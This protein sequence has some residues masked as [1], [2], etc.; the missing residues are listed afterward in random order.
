MINLLLGPPGGGKSYEAVV[1]HVL[2]A[3]QAGRR[4]ITNLPLDMA[5]L[6]AIDPGF[7][8]LVEIRHA[9]A[10]VRGTWTPGG[11]GSAFTLAGQ[12]RPSALGTRAFSSPWCFWTEQEEGQGGPLFVVDECHL[13]MPRTG[14]NREL[15]EW[16]S[17]HRHFRCDV[18]L[19]TQSYGKLSKA[20]CDLVQI[21]YR[22]RKNIAFGSSSSYVR[23]VQDGLRGE[24][25]NTSIRRYE[26]RF[27][28]VYKS[29]TQTGAGA[30]AA[31]NDIKPIWKH[32]TFIGA[33]LLLSSVAVAAASGL[34][35][36]PLKPPA[37]EADSQAKQPQ[38]LTQGHQ[39]PPEPAKPAPA[40]QVAPVS[41]QAEHE[42]PEP[43]AG[44]GI[45]MTGMAQMGPFVLYTFT[46]SQNGQPVL[47]VTHQD[48]VEAGYGWQG[49]GPCAGVLTFGKKV[50]AVVCDSPQVSMVKA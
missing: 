2:P 43:F 42:A 40:P 1:H 31:A 22:V 8:H 19:I 39:S 44:H 27:F 7:P 11:N 17:L 41:E 45:H 21:V 33:G 30:E 24:V 26:K 12:P 28:G 34:V 16:F 5:R 20:I 15:E 29:H 46:V 47:T 4:V 13:S 25:V 18:L 32:W 3:L 50:R 38:R 23:K 36:N 6:A 35:P 48:L 14:T 49:R 9:A 10:P 37:A